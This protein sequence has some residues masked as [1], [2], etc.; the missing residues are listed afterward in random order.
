MTLTEEAQL[1]KSIPS[2]E[3][4]RQ[5]RELAGIGVA[6]FAEEIGVSRVTLN[7]WEN[8]RQRPRGDARIR[9]ARALNELRTIV[10]TP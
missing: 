3:H 7:G 5:I 9:Y 10:E 2:P 8:G 4:A 6:R 1:L